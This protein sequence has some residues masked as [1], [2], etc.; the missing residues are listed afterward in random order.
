MNDTVALIPDTKQKGKRRLN[1]T[2]E[3]S[4]ID[5]PQWGLWAVRRQFGEHGSGCSP[6]ERI[7]FH[8][9]VKR[10]AAYS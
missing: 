7:D 3:L 8:L 5:S 2:F 4:T 9:H 10:S 1:L 6:K